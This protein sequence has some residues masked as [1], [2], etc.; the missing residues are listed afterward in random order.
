MN[1]LLKYGKGNF[2]TGVGRRQEE[3]SNSFEV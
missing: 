2:P 1:A 3:N